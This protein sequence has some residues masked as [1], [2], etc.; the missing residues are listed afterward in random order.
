[1]K[2]QT[3]QKPY[4]WKERPLSWSAISS[5]EYDP[6]QWY[7]KYVLNIQQDTTKEMLFGKNFATSIEEG[8]CT[9]PELLSMLQSKIEH[10]FKCKF[11]PVKA[12][13]IGYADSFCD[14][15]FKKLE[16]IK[17]GKK[18]W[19]QERADQ[20]GQ[21]SMYVLMNYLINKINPE[22]VQCRIHWIKTQDNGD[23]SISF[24]EPIS[25]KT[26]YTKRTMM[27][28]L[29]FG[30]RINRVYNQMIALCEEKGYN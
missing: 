3:K 14:K 1:M 17:T 4:N 24:V 27:D 8:K 5:F 23:F 21:I 16:E 12:G 26:F 10:P 25:I 9:I 28:I 2:K 19:T 15:T 6:E 18:E 20:H 22:E 30:E 29:K 7:Q 11:E 13:L